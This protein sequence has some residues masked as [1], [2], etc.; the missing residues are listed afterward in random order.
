[1]GDDRQRLINYLHRLTA[2][3]ALELHKLNRAM[4]RKNRRI[5][6]LAE[7]VEAYERAIE[8]VKSEPLYK[9]RELNVGWAIKFI[10]D[11]VKGKS[12]GT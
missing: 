9:N 6:R 10:E 2:C 11:S 5:K 4:L 3:Q 7:K 1:M 8:A 12:G